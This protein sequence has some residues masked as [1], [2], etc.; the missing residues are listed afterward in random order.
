MNKTSRGF[1]LIEVM[2]SIALLA[3]VI[4]AAF[5]IMNLF[6]WFSHE[7]N[8]RY[9]LF[10]AEA[11]IDSLKSQPFESLPPFVVTAGKDGKVVLPGR[12]VIQDS[13]RLYSE[14]RQLPSSSFANKDGVLY[15]TGA[16]MGKR[17][18]AECRVLLPSIEEAVTVPDKAPFELHLLNSPVTEITGVREVRG[19]SFRTLS[20]GVCTAVKDDVVTVNEGL[21]GKVLDFTYYGERLSI[22]MNGVF[23]TDDLKETRRASSLKLVTL[24]QVYGERTNSFSLTFL[25]TGGER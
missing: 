22:C 15:V 24:E 20:K 8:Y 4:P 13:I 14:G 10:Q 7:E 17:L 3:I 19:G 12:R 16:F 25:K 5:H 21:A 18:V 11:Q 2:I 6:K 23:V 1:T 9:A